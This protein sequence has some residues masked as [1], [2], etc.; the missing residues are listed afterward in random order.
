MEGRKQ[1]GLEGARDKVYSLQTIFSDLYPASSFPSFPI[2]NQ[3]KILIV[4]NSSSILVYFKY[5]RQISYSIQQ[6]RNSY[7]ERRRKK[8]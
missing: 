3:N 1:R 8:P 6:C 7:W 2:S 4:Q 5:T